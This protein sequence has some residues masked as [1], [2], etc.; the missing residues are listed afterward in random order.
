MVTN[1][2][3]IN[4]HFS[5][6]C[7]AIF[8]KDVQIKVKL[9]SF[10]IPQQRSFVFFVHP[11]TQKR[12]I[13]FPTPRWRGRRR[14]TWKWAPSNQMI[15]C[16]CTFVCAIFLKLLNIS[17]S[18]CRYLSIPHDII[19]TSLDHGCDWWNYVAMATISVAWFVYAIVKNNLK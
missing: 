16:S 1:N 14:G 17:L 15:I 8:A 18:Y 10:N 9:I 4:N 6:P 2:T 11:I 12:H 19:S 7:I 5:G 13:L 3:I